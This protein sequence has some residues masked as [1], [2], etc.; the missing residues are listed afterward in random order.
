M[1]NSILVLTLAVLLG[2]TAAVAQKQTPPEGSTPKDFVLPP[3]TTFSLDN[4][5]HATLIPYGTLPKVT[6][7]AVVRVGN[8]NEAPNEVWLCDLLGDLMKEGTT[9][10]SAKQLAQEAAKLGGNISITTG[11]DQTLIEG[12]VLTEFAPKMVELIADLIRHPAL[13]ESELQR[14]KNDRIRQLSIDKTDPTQI[15]LERFRAVMFPNHPYGRLQPTEKMLGSYKI[16]QLRD[17]YAANYGAAR[18]HVYVAGKFDGKATEEA[19]RKHFGDWAHGPEPLINIPKPVSQR[20]IYIVDRP[21]ASQST[22]F[23]GLPTIDPSNPDHRAL[24][25]TNS[26]LGGSFGSRITANIREDK[27]YTYSPNSSLSSRYRNAYWTQY[28]SLTTDVTGPALK[29]IFYEINRLRKEAPGEAELKGIQNYLA[30]V[31]VLQNSSPAGIIN[32]LSFLN[33]HGLPKSYLTEYV[34]TVYAVTPEQVRQITE[35]YLRPD[36]ML[37]VIAGDKMKVEKQAVQFGKLAQR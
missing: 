35:K 24:I 2:T 13:P 32:Q 15:A 18:T 30:G 25:V 6:V 34:K 31:F 12:S 3:S 10:R 8:L 14:L 17:F 19:I 27:G 5:L 7:R 33:L 11:A 16:D 4:G 26:L 9:S 28:A 22:V 20:A 1:K 23:L 29:Q 37:I 21:G 36:E